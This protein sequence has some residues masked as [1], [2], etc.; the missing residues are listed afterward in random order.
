[1]EF[2]KSE[3]REGHG[4]APISYE[5]GEERMKGEFVSCLSAKLKKKMKTQTETASISNP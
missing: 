4:A 5:M 2:I 3:K 1:M